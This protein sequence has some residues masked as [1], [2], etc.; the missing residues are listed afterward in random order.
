MSNPDLLL[1]IDEGTSS[2][3]AI[4]FDQSFAPVAQAQFKHRPRHLCRLR[5][6]EIQ[7]GP[8]RNHT[9]DKHVQTAHGAA[10]L[11]RHFRDMANPCV[12]V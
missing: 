7:T 6:R 12:N 11:C 2:T 1:V 3:R 8:L 4:I 5:N 10:L 9:V